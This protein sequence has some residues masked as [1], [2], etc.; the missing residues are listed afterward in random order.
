MGKRGPLPTK[1]PARN[2]RFE[3]G[4]GEKIE[5]AAQANG[6]S[7]SE[8]VSRRVAASFAE[9]QPDNDLYFSK[10]ESAIAGLIDEV[11]YV[12]MGVDDPL[13]NR[14]RQA[15]DDLLAAGKLRIEARDRSR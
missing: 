1:G 9:P 4:L 12:K 7:F 10:I 13:R 11:K 5:A 8:E 2:I 15:S 3:L 6:I 14:L